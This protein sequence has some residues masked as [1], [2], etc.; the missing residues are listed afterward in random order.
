MNDEAMRRRM[1]WEQLENRGIQDK[2]VLS[3]FLEI[4]RHLFVSPEHRSGS[5]EDHPLP[6]GQ[7][8]TISQPYMVALMTEQLRV[9][10]G[11]KI[12][13]IGTGSGYQAAILAHL[14]AK[15]YSVERI[16]PLA[17]SAMKR[18]KNLGYTQVEIRVGDGSLGWPS[19]APFDGILV[20]A[21]AP[22]LPQLLLNQLRE[23]GSLVIPIGSGLS[24]VLIL[25]RR[26]HGQIQSEE[27]CGC[28]FVPLIGAHGFEEGQ[29]S[30]EETV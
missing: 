22:R 21:A 15:V 9:H 25:A 23:G 28:V 19:A 20:T 6:I 16:A 10:S 14:G 5:Y 2:K 3:A 29:V 7:G 13:E 11:S 8:Q 27:V 24:Q 30:A 18:L 12:L 17:Q 26:L 1:V 4:P